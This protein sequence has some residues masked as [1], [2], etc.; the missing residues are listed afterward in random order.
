MFC[1]QADLIEAD[2]KE[3]A[4]AQLAAPTASAYLKSKELILKAYQAVLAKLEGLGVSLGDFPTELDSLP[5]SRYE[6][7]LRRQLFRCP[8]ITD[9]GY[10][11]ISPPYI[12]EGDCVCI[13]PGGR[14]PYILR[15][16]LESDTFRLVGGAYVHGVMNGE[17]L[18]T[19]R[20]VRS[21]LLV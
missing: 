13:F 19:E 20:E 1:E 5:L 9:N 11:G 2:D 14:I 16:Q 15:P 3:Y 17:Y 7:E 6:R 8:F 10:V 18:Q 12:Q 4:C 21:F